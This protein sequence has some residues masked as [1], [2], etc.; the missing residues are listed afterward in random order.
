[1][2][3]TKFIQEKGLVGIRGR[4]G[5]EDRH[6]GVRFLGG[7]EGEK[8]EGSENVKNRG[9]KTRKRGKMNQVQCEFSD[10]WRNS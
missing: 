2:G 1:L 3:K 6:T 9:K 4:E 10:Q 7:V 8:K 5:E